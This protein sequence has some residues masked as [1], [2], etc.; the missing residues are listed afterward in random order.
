[1]FVVVAG[2]LFSGFQGWRWFQDSNTERPT[3]WMAGYV[4]VTATPNYAFENPVS[5]AGDHVVL[6]FVVASTEDA[7][8]PSWGT[9]YSLAEADAALDLDRRIARRDQQGGDVIVSFGGQLNDELATGCT[10]A[11][12]LKDAYESVIDRYD[13]NTIDLDLEGD[14]LADTAAGERRAGVIATIQKQRASTDT[15]LAVWLTLPVLPTGLTPE[16]TDAVAK[17][18]DA[19]VDLAG[20]NLMTMDYGDSRGTL[21]MVDASEGA[22]NGT[23]AQLKTLYGRQGMTLGS[24]Q[25]WNKIGM[26]PMVG[27]NDVAGE[28]LTLDDAVALNAFALDNGVGRVSLWSLNRDQTCGSN[29]PDVTRVSDSCSGVQQGDQS[30]ATLLGASFTGTP[31]ANAAAVTTAEPTASAADLLDDPD[32]SPY[33]VWSEEVAYAKD[34]KVVWHKE[35]YIAKYW[36]QGDLPDNPVLQSTETPWTLLGPVLPGE[37]P[38]PLATLEPGAFPEW[39]GTAVYTEGDRVM[40]ESITYE[41]K[42]WTTGDSPQAAAVDADSSPWRQLTAAEITALLDADV[43]G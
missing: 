17:M 41:A 12:A 16:G 18:L 28:I 33:Q 21:S 10:D 37:T 4:D 26:T 24:K 22:L 43:A 42:W 6:S 34:T 11:S 38:V 15:P 32:A 35:V 23:H 30:Y 14:N 31:H 1:M 25:L 9:F 3:A 8:E 20:V 29:Y 2:L 39:D 5:A 13:L 27:Q 7:C 36:T 19:G 40:F